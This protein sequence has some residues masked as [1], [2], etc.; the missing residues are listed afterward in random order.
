[1]K[2]ADLIKDAPMSKVH[3]KI[4]KLKK[5]KRYYIIKNKIL[6]RYCVFK[7]RII[8]CIKNNK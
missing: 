2:F 8:N 3:D 5:Y 4:R 7:R 6:L 1:M